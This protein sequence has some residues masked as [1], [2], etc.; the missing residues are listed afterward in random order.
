[1]AIPRFELWNAPLAVFLCWETYPVFAISFIYAWLK[2]PLLDRIVDFRRQHEG[3]SVIAS[4]KIRHNHSRFLRLIFVYEMP[5]FRKHLQLVFACV[6]SARF[7]SGMNSLCTL[8][9]ADHEL[10]VESVCA[11]EQK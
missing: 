6:S 5:C 9:L 3:A 4:V 11:R 1:M 7:Y 10:F 2:L 8:H